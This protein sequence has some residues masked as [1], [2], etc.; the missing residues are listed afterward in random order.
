MKKCFVVKLIPLQ[1]HRKLMTLFQSLM[2]SN[3][4]PV[5]ITFCRDHL[6]RYPFH[7]FV[8]AQEAFEHKVYAALRFFHF[9][10]CPPAHLSLQW[11]DSG[12]HH[13]ASAHP[14]ACLLAW[15]FFGLPVASFP[16]GK[17][18]VLCCPAMA[19]LR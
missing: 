12:C 1:I 19:S 16:S 7:S 3:Y 18:A 2:S 9:L 13:S 4:Y 6:Y 17:L 11:E 15:L 10:T 5:R 14:F 8:L